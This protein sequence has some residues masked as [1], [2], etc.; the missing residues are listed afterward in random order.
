MYYKCI[1][2]LHVKILWLHTYIKNL[3][4]F[5]I[6]RFWFFEF[7]SWWVLVGEKRHLTTPDRINE[8][9][10]LEFAL[11]RCFRQIEWGQR[12]NDFYDMSRVLGHERFPDEQG[13]V[14]KL[15]WFASRNYWWKLLRPHMMTVKL[16]GNQKKFRKFPIK[17]YAKHCKAIQPSS[18]H[19]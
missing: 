11:G 10:S 1:I 19:R 4:I 6:L 3:H 9:G 5:W 2:Y 18:L 14:Y 17:S 13:M 8:G 15:E 12:A 7:E 16:W